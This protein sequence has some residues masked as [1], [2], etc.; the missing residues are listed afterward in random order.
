VRV[1]LALAAA[2]FACLVGALILGEYEFE[3]ATPFGA[4]ILFGLVI[5]EIVI[6]IGRTRGPLLGVISAAMVAAALA[7]AAYISS[8]EGLRPFPTGGWIAL[9]L[10]ALTAGV[11]VGWPAREPTD[12]TATE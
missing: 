1:L 10:A 11:R 5:S 6:E 7:R 4:G 8:G 12:V 2:A 3:G 9:V